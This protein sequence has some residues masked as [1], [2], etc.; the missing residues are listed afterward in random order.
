MFDLEEENDMG[1]IVALNDTS[2]HHQMGL[3]NK[4]QQPIIELVSNTRWTL[5]LKQEIYCNKY[6]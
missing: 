2:S 3:R 4:F 5:N 1:I 6:F